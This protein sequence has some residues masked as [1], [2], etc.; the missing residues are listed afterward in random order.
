LKV[1][2]D[3][4]G[5]TLDKVGFVENLGDYKSRLRGKFLAGGLK[6]SPQVNPVDLASAQGVVIGQFRPLTVDL[7]YDFK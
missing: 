7:D 4:L 6:F 1:F 5:F 2:K 3:N